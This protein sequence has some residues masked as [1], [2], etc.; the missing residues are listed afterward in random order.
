[1]PRAAPS[2]T[3]LPWRAYL[4]P[5]GLAL[6]AVLTYVRALPNPFVYDDARTIVGNTSLTDLSAWRQ[7]L[8]HDVKRPL[9]N[10]SYAIDRAVWGLDPR[11]FHL[12]TAVLHAIA[13]VLLFA[14]TRRIVQDSAR[15]RPAHLCARCA[16]G[17]AALLFAVHPA[18]T[19]AVGYAS[20][21]PEVLC[22]VWFLASLLL[23]RRYVLVGA[24]AAL[25]FGALAWIA[26][27]ASKEVGAMLPLVLA[28]WGWTAGP[29]DGAGRHRLNVVLAWVL[30][31][32]VVAG[33]GRVLLL[34]MI[35]N[36]GDVHVFWSHLLVQPEVAVRY[37]RL[38]VMPSH[39]SV[40]HVVAA[41]A[42]PLSL[43]VL[44]PVALLAALG[45]IAWRLRRVEPMAAFGLLWFLLLVVPSG[46]LFVV[47]I[48][49]PMAEQRIY[50]AG[51]GVFMIAGTA[52]AWLRA[53]TYGRGRR[54]S[55]AAPAIVALAA[56]AL[57]GATQVR[58]TAWSS[59]ARLWSD[60][61]RKAPGA[62][63][64]P[65]MLGDAL[66][67]EGRARDAIDAYRRAVAIRGDQPIIWV[68]LGMLLLQAGDPA[69]A[70]RALTEAL[71]LDPASA[72]AS[73]GLGA[74]AMMGGHPEEARRRFEATLRVQP[75]D[76]PARQLLAALDEQ[77]GRRDEAL[78][79]CQ[80][81][82]AAAPGTPG[83]DECI[84]RNTGA[85]RR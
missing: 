61:E 60:A 34:W 65:L 80:E 1:M 26:S 53:R 22:A 9:V 29:A 69:G 64:P 20:G 75:G 36:P 47:N 10:L 68:K 24:R 41:I 85:L 2:P 48:G 62:W 5:L 45:V 12:T 79:R 78:R 74:V 77:S 19:Q 63:V 27:L 57:F 71:R 15:D 58:L 13:V 37:L 32:A 49:E 8:W 23:L 67:A 40:F 73:N 31:L 82:R 28:A 83:I 56:C 54:L 81:V 76:V 72:T 51:C 42:S 11:G 16:A 4:L 17:A 70:T 14:W 30:A 33:T 50:L 66:D 46:V 38:L 55:F 7:I 59:A 25:V 18:M 39:L 21:R 44:G 6:A 43:R 3:R 35:E 84:A 52:S